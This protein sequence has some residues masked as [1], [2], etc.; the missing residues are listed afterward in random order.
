M[1][2]APGENPGP[3]SSVAPNDD[4][5][6]P[7][8]ALVV[9]ALAYAVV[10]L[11]GW[12]G[13]RG[14]IAGLPAWSSMLVEAAVSLTP[15]VIGALLAARLGGP[16]IARALGLRFRVVDV[17]LGA[18]VALVAR[19]VV[20]LVVPT[21]GTL[22]PTLDGGAGDSVAIVVMAIVVLGVLAPV[23]EELYF[24]GAVQRALQSALRRAASPRVAGGIAVLLTTLAFVIL[25]AVP[26]GTAVPV[27]VVLPPLLVGLGAG[28]LTAVT[29]RISGGMTAHILFNLAGLLLL[30]R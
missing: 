27:S 2:T 24:R 26:Y 5:A 23:A 20:E 1:T 10:V 9:V 11:L 15:L 6:R 16:R 8:V 30:L 13:V 22:L 14:P 12:P 18:L 19:A 25:H 4:Y 28:T 21:S 29:G 7:A 17:L 3:S